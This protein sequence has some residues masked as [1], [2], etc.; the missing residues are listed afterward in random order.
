MKTTKFRELL[1]KIDK[2]EDLKNL[3]YDELNKF[4]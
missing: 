4:S 1:G 2:P 3:N